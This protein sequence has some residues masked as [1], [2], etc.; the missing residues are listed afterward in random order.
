MEV[1]TLASMATQM[2]NVRAQQTHET[3][4]LKK[5]IDLQAA[6]ALQLLASID[7][8]QGVAPID[9]SNMGQTIDVRV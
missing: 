4:V 9:G 7:P 3:A 5:A 1:S 8:A 2:S 6:G